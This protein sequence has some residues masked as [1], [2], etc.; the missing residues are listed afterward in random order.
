MFE[1]DFNLTDEFV[2]STYRSARDIPLFIVSPSL[3]EE[4]AEVGKA[5]L[6]WLSVF[7]LWFI[8]SLCE[9]RF[10]CR[11]KLEGNASVLPGLASMLP[12]RM[13]L[14][15]LEMSTYHDESSSTESYLRVDVLS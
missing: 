7:S 11:P 14:M 2:S 3:Y 8:V 4:A 6:G 5:C 9:E 10:T 12:G 15:G 13:Y 1:L